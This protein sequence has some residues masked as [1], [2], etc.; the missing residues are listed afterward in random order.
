MHGLARQLSIMKAVAFATYKE[1]AAYRT[2]A[3]VSAFC[4]PVYFLVQYFIWTAVY[5]N[6]STING[7]TLNQMLAYFGLSAMIGYLTMDYADWNLQMLIQTG[8]YTTF[9]L[10]PMSHVFFALSQKVGHRALGFLFEFVPVYLI[11]V[12]L[13]KIVLLPAQPFWAVL[14]ITLAFLMMFFFDYCI[15]ITCFWL[16]KGNAA[17]YIFKMLRDICSGALFPLMLLPTPIQTV[18]FFLPFQYIAYVP[19]RVCIGT[20]S[21]GSISMSLPEIVFIQAICVAV[22]GCLTVLFNRAGVKRFTGVGA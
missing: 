9:R 21:L 6:R 1:W 10:R 3:L 20:Y 16:I 18:F 13:F 5:A 22:M 2:H 17:R 4:G 15:G 11:F 14:S 19:I 7:M 8:K 12:F